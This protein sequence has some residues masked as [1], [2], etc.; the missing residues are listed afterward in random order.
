MVPD[1]FCFANLLRVDAA[2][3]RSNIDRRALI[4]AT[5][6]RSDDCDCPE[7]DAVAWAMQNGSTAK[8]WAVR[9][10]MRK[11]CAYP[12]VKVSTF[13]LKSLSGTLGS[14]NTFP[15]EWLNPGKIMFAFTGTLIYAL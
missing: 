13:A 1:F 6:V 9:P 14:V 2:P 4:S 15:C 3:P 11:V 10:N 5:P 7:T 12:S 8:A